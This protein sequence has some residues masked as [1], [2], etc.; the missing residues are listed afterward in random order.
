MPLLNDHWMLVWKSRATIDQESYTHIFKNK[1]AARN[2]IAP[3]LCGSQEAILQTQFQ[4]SHMN[5]STWQSTKQQCDSHPSFAGDSSSCC[6]PRMPSQ[7]LCALLLCLWSWPPQT[8]SNR[9]LDP[10]TSGNASRKLRDKWGYLIYL[11]FPL[12]FGRTTCGGA[13]HLDAAFI[14]QHFNHLSSIYFF[15]SEGQP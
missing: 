10:H 14:W 6:D 8:A 11:C 13:S 15:S 2:C 12:Y 1:V 7:P 5:T 3:L 4:E 9:V